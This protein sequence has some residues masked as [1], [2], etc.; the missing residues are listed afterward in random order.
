MHEHQLAQLNVARTVA[1]IDDPRM[2]DFVAWLDVINRLAERSTGFV[3]R[4]HDASGNATSLPVTDDPFVIANLTV[5]RSVEDLRVFTYR[6]DHRLVFVRRYEWFERWPGPSVVMWWIPSRDA[7]DRRR[8][9][10]APRAARRRGPDAGRVHVQA[11]VPRAGTRHH[12]TRTGPRSAYGAFA[13]S[14]IR[15]RT[16]IIHRQGIQLHSADP[17]GPLPS[18][19][20]SLSIV[21]S[22]PVPRR[23]AP[24]PP[25]R[26]APSL[27]RD[28]PQTVA[29]WQRG[30]TCR[31]RTASGPSASP[32][33]SPSQASPPRPSP[34]PPLTPSPRTSSSPRRLRPPSPR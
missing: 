4:L 29:R 17:A 16:A 21:L 13:R 28:V 22:A 7:A 32:R 9:A 15:F 34:R 25:A 33:L 6:S 2:A 1:P 24:S 26:A 20:L 5:W 3:W 27:R 11:A 30:A 14:L 10:R 12:L 18:V 19:R 8:R 31:L 23:G